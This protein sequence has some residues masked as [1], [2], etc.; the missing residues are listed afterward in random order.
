MN[1]LNQPEASSDEAKLMKHMLNQSARPIIGAGLLCLMALSS[2][3]P[4]ARAGLSL[5]MNMYR[6]SQGQ[7]YV[8]YTPLTTNAI[9]PAAAVGTYIISSPGWPASGSRRGFEMTTTNVLIDRT[10]FDSENSYGDFNSAL[11]QITNGAWTIRF[12]NAV[13]TNLYTFKVSAPNFTSNM[14]PATVITFPLD[15]SRI[16]P[17]QTNFTWHAPASWPVSGFVYVA[18]PSY[19]AGNNFPASATNW[20]LP[21]PLPV[22]T[23]YSFNLNFITNFVSNIFTISTPT[24]NIGGA[25]ISG[26]TSTA[27]ISSGTYVAFDVF[28]PGV[29]SSGHTN[30][31]FYSFEDDSLFAHDFSGHGNNINSYGNYSTPPYITNDAA[32]GSYALGSAGDGWLYPPT[33]LLATLAGSFTVSLWLKTSDVHGN[34]ADG[35]Y[36]AAGIVSAFNGSGND[37]LPMGLTGGK[38]LFYTGGSSQNLLHSQASINTGQYVHVVVTRDQLT[39]EKKIYLNGSLDSSA[40]AST[41]LL[42]G[43]DGLS[44]G[45]NNGQVFTGDRDEIQFYSGVLSAD[46]VTYLYNHPGTNVADAVGIS[47]A[48]GH[49]NVAHYDFDDSGTPGQDSS[50]N[51]N[52][53][54]GPTTWGPKYLFDADAEAGGG[55]VRFFGTSCLYADG[56]TLTNLNAVLAG[57]FTFSAWVKTTVSNGAD[58]DDAVY[59][60]AIFWAY[61]DQGY[62]NDT[63]PLSI[64][65]S[66]AAFTTR[67]HTGNNNTLH[68]LTSVNDGNYHLITVTRDQTTGEKKIYVDGNFETSQIGTT[69]P[70]NGNDYRLTIGGWAYCTDSNCT[71]FYA[72]NGLLDDVQI[73]SGVLSGSDVAYLYANPGSN[74]VDTT[75]QDFNTAL[76]TTDLA[77]TTGGDTSW[78]VETTNTHDNVAAVQSGSVTDNQSS[79]LS[80]TVTGP[81]TLTFYWSSIAEDSGFDYEF[82][83]DGVYAND[84][85]GDNSWIQD[86]PYHVE[87][88]QHTFTWTTYANGDTDPTQAGFLDQVSFVN[89]GV[90][91]TFSLTVIRQTYASDQP[92]VTGQTGFYAFPGLS[93]SDTPVSYHRVESPNGNFSAN[94]GPTNGGA[95]AS[96]LLTFNELAD[97]LTNGNW[98]LWLNKD[99]PQEKLYTFT[100][101]AFAFSSNSLAPVHIVAP[102]DGASAVATNTPYQWTGPNTW[103]NLTTQAWLSR[104]GTNYYYANANLPVTT[105]SWP[106]GPTLL[107]GTNF[108]NVEYDQYNVTNFVVGSPYPEWSVGSIGYQSS[109]TAGFLVSGV[110]ALPATLLN[111]KNNNTNFQFQFLSQAG[112]THAIQYRTNLVQ[113]S[114]WQTYS[115]VTGDGT[116]KTIPIPLTVFSP[117]K[118]GFVRV[119]SQ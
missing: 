108:F 98:K 69:D 22:D 32:V 89:S 19:F 65:G 103:S 97:S 9:A 43:S 82:D 79:T 117:S 67:D 77:W 54:S 20:S 40:Y 45:Y 50:G 27:V 61:N 53:M 7:T 36:S 29:P 56:Q 105:V 83:I 90:P 51:G 8:F 15:G 78:L 88:G 71:N 106:A 26:W 73:Y 1:P 25:P 14:L 118:Q 86:G 66:K 104:S 49:K 30:V 52:D 35:Q 12:T 55:A 72:Y 84:I 28:Q 102:L 110:T 76:N 107:P 115:N 92:F 48:G 6:T 64:T 33:N 31:A 5:E 70:L 80:V 91:L 42:T 39:G 112:Y 47:L 100:V 111:P 96:I 21:N 3:S 17:G 46:E 16:T 93:G 75:G 2:G 101:N 68:S 44:I 4:A 113:G 99:T 57:S 95:G 116:L 85:Y 58:G 119:L 74:V 37:V 11:Q 18:G 81:G 60:A 62:T 10:E 94:F 63:I 114:N 41:D 38:L 87:S 23:G 59:G 13:S 34:D 24:N 109:A